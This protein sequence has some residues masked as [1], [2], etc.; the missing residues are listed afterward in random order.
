MSLKNVVKF[1]FTMFSFMFLMTNFVFASQY[2]GMIIDKIQFKGIMNSDEDRLKDS[3]FLK[4]GMKFKDEQAEND[5]KNLY[6]FGYFTDIK[7][8]IETTNNQKLVITYILKEKPFVKEIELQ[9][10]NAVRDDDI[11]KVLSNK[12]DIFYNPFQLEKDKEE[13]LKLYV[14]EGYIGTQVFFETQIDKK[15]RLTFKVVVWEGYRIYIK[16]VDING[17]LLLNRD[18]LRDNLPHIKAPSALSFK[19]YPFDNTEYKINRILFIQHGKNNGFINFKILKTDIKVIISYKGYLKD[20]RS[21]FSTYIEK[22]PLSNLIQKLDQNFE[23]KDFETALATLQNFVEK[24]AKPSY[25]DKEEE[26][27]WRDMT[28]W[29]KGQLTLYKNVRSI[30]K[31][32]LPKDS[33]LSVEYSNSSKNQG[34]YITYTID[35]GKR[36]VFGGVRIRGNK[37]IKTKKIRDKLDLEIGEVYNDLKFIKFVQGSY[38]M[39][40][41]FGYFYAK[42]TPIRELDEEKK[43]V[44]YTIDIY[45]GDQV[46]IE[47]MYIVGN[48]KTLTKVI[49]RELRIKEGEVYD[50]SKLVR[51]RERL[52]RTQYF[53]VAEFQEKVG[54]EEGLI[55]VFWRVEEN[56]TGM[57][58]IGG[59]YGTLTGFNIFGQVKES[60]LFGAGYTGTIK[61]QYGQTARSVTLS[62][63]SSWIGY[64]PLSYSI[65]ASFGWQKVYTVP[66]YDRDQNGVWDKV[67]YRDGAYRLWQEGQAHFDDYTDYDRN[68]NYNPTSN[69]V[70]VGNVATGFD[71][72]DDDESDAGHNYKKHVISFG[73]S[74]GYPIAEYWRVY[75]GQGFMYAKYSDPNKINWDYLYEDDEYR[76][77]SL[78]KSEKFE[79]TTSSSLSLSFDNT[80][81]TLTPSKG[82][83]FR[84]SVI[85]YGVEGGYN[86][87]TLLSVDMSAYVTFIRLKKSKWNLIWANHLYAG[88]ITKLPGAEKRYLY[89]ERRLR[90]DGT[91]EMRGWQEEVDEEYLKGLGKVSFSSELR[92]PIIGTNNLLWWTFFFDAG[93]VTQVGASLPTDLE[94]YKFSY[95]FGLRIEMP[96]FP[97]RFYFGKRMLWNNGWFDEEDGFNFVLSIAGFF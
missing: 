16:E 45:E 63:G 42:V 84:P 41:H 90:F 12:R 61:A 94:D 8:D 91:T 65:S 21:K 11:M 58:T 33:N 52:T 92:I 67:V 81:N 31:D 3:L 38:S 22:K 37:K 71:Y 40:K 76:L 29:A 53:K 4:K 14:K 13:I 77:K 10:N 70:T 83:K 74:M 89:A 48:S 80:D 64:I 57:L 73:I 28:Q 66:K 2:E 95:G 15:N 88:T 68:G 62:F 36:Y 35:E 24:E 54:S 27:E 50:Y 56:R 17:D 85:F 51:S 25:S 44:Y 19:T 72:E 9:G 43:A 39:Y 26:K 5:F 60:N 20:L 23:K 87:F 79:L 69:G 78:L 1:L 93:N 96:M 97:I 47:N 86:R 34:Y 32:Q 59:G 55:D 49:D 75:A 30:L 7:L 46:H 6:A 82:V 18:N